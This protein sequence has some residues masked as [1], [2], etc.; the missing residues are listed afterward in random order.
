M[1]ISVT[2]IAYFSAFAISG[3]AGTRR[4]TLAALGIAL[5]V[6]IL[7]LLKYSN[8]FIEGINAVIG[9]DSIRP[10]SLLVPVGLSFYSLQAISYLADVYGGRTQAERSFCL[11]AAALSFFPAI[12][13]GPIE[14]IRDLI[15]RI[16][17]NRGP[18]RESFDSGIYLIVEGL[19]LKFAIA[20]RLAAHTDAVF[21]I[22]AI[23]DGLTLLF[24]VLLFTVQIYCDFAGYS[25]IAIGIARCMGI[26]LM[27]NFDTP[28]FSR[29]I[30]EFWRRWHISFSTWLKDYIYIPLGGNRVSRFRKNINVFI[31]FLVSGLWHGANT[32]FIVWGGLHGIYNMIPS[33]VK[34]NDS[35]WKRIVSV[36]LTFIA[37]SFAWIF[38]RASSVSDAFL[39]IKRI[40]TTTALNVTSLQN[41][42][43]PFTGDNTS[44][45]YAGV[46]IALIFLLW[47][48]EWMVN[49]RKETAHCLR[50]IYVVIM[51]CCLILF[52]KFGNGGFIYANF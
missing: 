9:T 33:S 50:P 43:L 16:R 47:V 17:D 12:T 39:V 21:A 48:K 6:A 26:K 40:A 46:S 30:K 13:S 38:F 42:I 5:I 7:L 10:L 20:D 31:T 44:V 29:S 19:F 51:T 37:V 15:P 22:P 4:K 24:S 1:L 14:R 18:T 23:Y 34:D 3:S 25:Q 11:F 35:A 36:V 41:M 52:G 32:T 45:A 27:D 28:Y 49:Y 2:L 8:F